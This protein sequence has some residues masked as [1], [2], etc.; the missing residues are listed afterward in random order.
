MWFVYILKC[1]DGTFYTGITKDIKDL[2]PRNIILQINFNEPISP[3]SAS[4]KVIDD[5]FKNILVSNKGAVVDGEFKISNGY[6]TVEF[7]PNNPCGQNACGQTVYCLPPQTT[8]V[9]TAKAA[10][11]KEIGLPTAVLPS[12][13]LVDMAANSLDGG[14]EFKYDV[15]KKDFVF[16]P[17]SVRGF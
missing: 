14:G 13:G 3:L 2:Q 16:P 12:D 17:A 15:G 4:G 1:S 6:R 9:V 11:L 8:L 7:V 5:S 10:T